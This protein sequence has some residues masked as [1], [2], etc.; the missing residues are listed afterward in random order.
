MSGKEITYSRILQQHTLDGFNALALELFNYQYKKNAIYRRFTDYL[1][2]VP[3][4]VSSPE[5][6][7][8]LPIEFFRTHKVISG[9][10]APGCI[11][12]ESS[13]TSGLNPSRHYVNDPSL[14]QESYTRGFRHFY[15]A[16]SEY[17]FLALLPSYLERSGSSLIYMI[18]HFMRLSGPGGGFY[19]DDHAALT[20]ALQELRKGDRKIIIWGVSFALLDLVEKHT[21]EIPEVLIMET[22]GMK[23]R[24]KELTRAE[25][26]QLLCD[27]FSVSSIHSEYGMTELLSQAYSAGDGRFHAPPWMKVMIREVNDPL[28]FAQPGKTGGI[29]IIDLANINSCCFIATQDLGRMHADGSFEVLG[30]FD[31]SDVRGCNLMVI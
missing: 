29:N 7:P 21:L 10:E 1:G 24:R 25:L 14:Y 17:H 11:L 3:A 16:P 30:R 2:V 13:G 12:F 28:A 5:Q 22:G 27:G 15:G 20:K 9:D 19:L 31:S 18:D 4:K 26:H 8:F 23:G 6:I